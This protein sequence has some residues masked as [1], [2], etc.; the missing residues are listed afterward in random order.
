MR[1]IRQITT[2]PLFA[3]AKENHGLSKFMTRGIEKAKKNSI[4]IASIQNLKRLMTFCKRKLPN[5][6]VK[7]K[8]SVFIN[9]CKPIHEVPSY[10]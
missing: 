10:V 7:D 5:E 6:K 4:L 9:M 3:E 1:R 2:E 8:I